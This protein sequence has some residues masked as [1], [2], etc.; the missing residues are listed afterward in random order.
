MTGAFAL[1]FG[2]RC[3]CCCCCC[4]A[5]CFLLLATNEQAV[6]SV[7]LAGHKRQA[8]VALIR[9]QRAERV[10]RNA[11]DLI[12]LIADARARCGIAQVDFVANLELLE[13]AEVC[14]ALVV[15]PDQD[16]ISVLQRIGSLIAA[17]RNLEQFIGPFANDWQL[18]IVLS[19]SET[20]GA[21]G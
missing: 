15:M 7:I 14:A 2:N 13:D 5:C 17:D 6:C 4:S 10:R 1:C 20:S 19:S 11:L 9:L 21:S 16:E 12:Y 18:N 8:S 3:W